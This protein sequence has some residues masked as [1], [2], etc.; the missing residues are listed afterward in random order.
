MTI[1]SRRAVVGFAALLFAACAVTAPSTRPPGSVGRARDASLADPQAEHIVVI[2]MENKEYSTIV[3]S[4]EAPYLNRLAR[5]KVL[6]K[7]EYAIAHPSLPDYLSLI[8]GS[9]FGITT[10]C[11]DCSVRG[12]NLVDELEAHGISWAAYMQSMPSACYTGATAGTSP[13]EYVKKHDPFLYFDD[14]RNR[15]RRCNKVVPLT[16]LGPDLDT[17]LPAFVWISPNECSDMHSCSISTGDDWLRRWVPR[18][19][20]ALG[21]NGIVVILFDEG[22]SDLGC[23][24]ADPGGGHVVAV[25]AGPGASD[26]TRIRGPVDHY[27]ILRLIEDEWGLRRLRHAADDST[28]SIEGWKAP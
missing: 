23:C 11:S 4:S 3:G 7:R 26:R 19:L 24:G 20:P 9:T 22:T 13:A 10:D 28:P 17:G 25:I 27:S 15:P 1:L 12:R 16:Q 8:G 18:I 5:Q 14:I 21:S 6:L 2:A